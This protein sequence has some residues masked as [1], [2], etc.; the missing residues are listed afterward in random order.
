MYR[1]DADLASNGIRRCSIVTG[2]HDDAETRA[3][4]L[5][6]GPGRRLLDGICNTEQPCRRA[7]DGDEHNRLPLLSKRDSL[8][9]EVRIVC[10]DGLH[11]F[12][13]AHGHLFS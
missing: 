12:F 3:M 1:I 2:Q 6:D 13:I 5:L 4:Q 9:S 7:V 11:Q 8:T 10:P